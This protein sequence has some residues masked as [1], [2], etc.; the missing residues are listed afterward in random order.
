M[1]LENLV[2][3]VDKKAYVD[4]LSDSDKA[5]LLTEME[6]KKKAAEDELIRLETMKTKLDED[7]AAQMEKLK[8]MGI[9]SYEDLDTEIEKLENEIN[10]EIVKYAEAL[11][12]R[13]ICLVTYMKQLI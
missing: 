9:A 8:S 11:K 13:I 10:S 3:Q 1:I 5:I 7:E 4:Q 2:N 6:Q 12:R